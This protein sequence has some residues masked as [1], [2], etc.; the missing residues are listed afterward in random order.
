MDL[1]EETL[2]IRYTHPL[3]PSPFHAPFAFKA[4]VANRT[5]RSKFR[6]TRSSNIN[7]SIE[8]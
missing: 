4:P 7:V 8:P 3:I 6:L 5:Q 1:S 2:P